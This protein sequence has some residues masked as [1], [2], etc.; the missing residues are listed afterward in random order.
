MRNGILMINPTNA[1]QCFHSNNGP[2]TSVQNFVFGILQISICTAKSAI[3]FQQLML[4]AGAKY[5]FSSEDLL[6]WKLR[7]FVVR[8]FDLTKFNVR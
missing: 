6:L 1:K 5:N 3:V 2:Y 7:S 4:L 8:S